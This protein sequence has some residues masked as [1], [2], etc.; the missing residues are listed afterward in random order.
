VSSGAIDVK[1]RTIWLV[2]VVGVL[3]AAGA[4]YAG[5]T[6]AFSP[7]AA[8]LPGFGGPFKLTDQDGR[9]VTDA[10]FRGKWLLVYFGYTHCP[11][12]CPTALNAIAEALDRLGPTRD[13]LQPV[14]ITLDPERDTP[15]VLKTYTSAFQAGIVGLT[16]SPTQIQA[17]ARAYR[18]TYR[19]H[20]Q[21]EDDDYTVDHTSVI[22]LIDPTGKPVSLFSHETPPDRLSHRLKAAIG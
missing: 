7:K 9:T 15:E 2:T 4:V 19:K 16:G 13:R 12:A 8:T 17:I 11:D 20:P 18:I 14:F 21:P 6:A 3:L 5:W 10:D 22:F 1:R